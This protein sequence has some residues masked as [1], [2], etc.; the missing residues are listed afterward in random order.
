[1]VSF[2]LII[3][4]LL[5]IV[6][7][8]AL[9]QLYKQVQLPKQEIPSKDM[10]DL[11]ETYLEDIKLENRRLEETLTDKPQEKQNVETDK[12]LETTKRVVKNADE[13]VYSTP[14]VGDDVLYETSTHAKVLQMHDQGMSI[15]EIARKTNS[16]KTEVDLIV[17]LHTKK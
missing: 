4:F 7:F 13:K 6:T 5:H 8:L 2:L 10:M 15:E 1:M 11:F 14:E 17:K 12:D 3:S 9:Y 16:G